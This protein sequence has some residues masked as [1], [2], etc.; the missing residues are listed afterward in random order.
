MFFINGP[1]SRTSVWTGLVCS[2]DS[3][4]VADDYLVPD[5]VEEE[6]CPDCVNWLWEG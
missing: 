4:I 3:D 1:A 2:V 6:N 5:M